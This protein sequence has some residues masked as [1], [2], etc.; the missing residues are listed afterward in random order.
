M[1]LFGKGITWAV[2]ALLAWDAYNVGLKDSVLLNSS[3]TLAER[4]I[5]GSRELPDLLESGFKIVTDLVNRVENVAVIASDAVLAEPP[6]TLDDLDNDI[7]FAFALAGQRTDISYLYLANTAHLESNFRL[8]AK[9]PTSSASGLF[10]VI[11]STWL[12]LL[13]RHGAK[14]GWAG[15]ANQI[16][17]SASRCT[18]DDPAARS[19][20]LALRFDG[21]I[22]TYLA[23]EFAAENKRTLETALSRAVSDYEL[24]VA[25]FL[26]V[27]GATKFFQNLETRPFAVAAETFPQAAKANRGVFYGSLGGART[28]RGVDERFQ[29][30]WAA[31]QP[32]VEAKTPESVWALVGL[33]DGTHPNAT[34]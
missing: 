30:R 3:L 2:C 33:R 28:F 5:E 24:Y 10:Q 8:D 16:K 15:Y 25:H 6:Q 26:G 32:Y 31:C 4:V 14:Y 18:V 34:L 9:A 19:E 21:Q 12:S 29:Q 17:C 20:I 22:A 7:V 27:S 11:D 13:K 23:A 1:F